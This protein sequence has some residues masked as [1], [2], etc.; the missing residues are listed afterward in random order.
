MAKS[1]P[2]GYR[3]IEQPDEL[4][5]AARR[6]AHTRCMAFDLEADSMYH[7]R[8]K[9][10]L[11]QIATNRETLVIDPLRVTDLAPLRPV[12][13]NR[14]I[15]KVLH[16]A[17]Y[18]IRSLYRDFKIEV[19]NLFDTELASRFLGARET[20]LD[21][22]LNERFGVRLNKK[23]Q[24]KDWSKRP[25]PAEMMN[26]AAGDVHHLIPLADILEKEL[27]AKG[28]LDWVR[29]ECDLLSLVRPPEPNH[30]PLFHNFK[31]AGR[32]APRNLAVLESLL[33]LRRRV[34]EAKDRPLFKV[35]SNK[36]LLTLATV[37]PTTAKALAQAGALSPKQIKIHGKALLQAI[38]SAHALPGD[39][40]PVYP[41]Q[42]SPRL[43]ARVP[44]RMTALKVWR[45]RKADQLG[46]DP[47]LML[48]K[49]LMQAIA[50]RHPQDMA[51]LKSITDLHAWRCQAFGRDIVGVMK[52]L[53]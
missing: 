24:R 25:L 10:C 14:R 7:F 34:A 19:H 43:P 18:D 38:Q 15:K 32:L 9:V 42:R 33:K 45:D 3:L 49:A 53:P 8:E 28:R 37:M 30:T 40:L 17:D 22:V 11:I 16:G 46:L 44:E 26:Y 39:K 21:A 29:E 23:Y 50:I 31:G 47:G 52:R 6:L 51:A 1:R 13:A 35:F 27:T 48:N 20:G 12:M 5:A 4:T 2:D 41:R 36:S